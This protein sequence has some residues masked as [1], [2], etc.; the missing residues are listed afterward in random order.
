VARRYTAYAEAI[1]APVRSWDDW[2]HNARGIF[3][4]MRS[5]NGE[6][7]GLDSNSF[8][9]RIRPNSIIRDLDDQESE[10][11]RRVALIGEA[12]AGWSRDLAAAR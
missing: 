11:L 7:L 5:G 2:P 4:A 3:Q 6:R 12:P 10:L 1:V 9:E 8:V